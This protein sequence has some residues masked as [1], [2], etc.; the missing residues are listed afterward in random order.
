[1]QAET[2]KT[3]QAPGETLWCFG[4]FVLWERQRRLE[5]G[6]EVIRLG[7][8]SF[9]QLMLLLKRAG[10]VVS[11]QEFLASVWSGVVVEECSVRVHMSILRKAL[12]EPDP[13]DEC[14]EWISTVP[15]RGYC[16]VGRVQCRDAACEP[17]RE[18]DHT[19]ADAVQ[20]VVARLFRQTASQSADAGEQV[21]EPLSAFIIQLLQALPDLRLLANQDERRLVG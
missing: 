15:L 2:T 20:A 9:D 8:R 4:S 17:V 1:M 12:G 7:S 3:V 13:Q 21:I 14:R 6:G 11:H 10:E 5:R 18:T 19:R 16:F